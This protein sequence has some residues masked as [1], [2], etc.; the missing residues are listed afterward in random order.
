[1]NALAPRDRELI[2]ARIEAE[3]SFA[4]IAQR[5]GSGTPD[6]ARMA[7]SRALKRLAER[8]KSAHQ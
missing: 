4:E 8:I 1:L 2:V 7:V 6:A 5:F 3:W